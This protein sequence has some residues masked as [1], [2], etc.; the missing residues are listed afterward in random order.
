MNLNFMNHSTAC[1]QVKRVSCYSFVIF[2]EEKKEIK[3]DLTVCS[4]SSK[5]HKI[6]KKKKSNT[7]KDFRMKNVLRSSHLISS[8]SKSPKTTQRL[9]AIG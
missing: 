2:L 7:D 1:C 4:D 3:V 8:L 5:L 9:F 6:F